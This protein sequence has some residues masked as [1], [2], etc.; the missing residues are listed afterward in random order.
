MSILRTWAGL[1]PMSC[2]RA[3]RGARLAGPRVLSAAST[4]T[5]RASPSCWQELSVTGGPATIC[6]P[7]VFLLSLRGA[8]SLSLRVAK[9]RSRARNSFPSLRGTECRSNLQFDA[10]L[11]RCARDDGVRW[12]SPR[13]YG[14]RD[15][16]MISSIVS[17]E[18]VR[19]SSPEQLPL[20]R[21]PLTQPP[22][23]CRP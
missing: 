2:P 22:P 1:W 7:P 20:Y 21:Q 9:R 4:Q 6:G 15:D 17:L 18:L 11:L 23:S 3:G 13:P 12:R 16:R 19:I 8:V 5:A 10:R 14:P